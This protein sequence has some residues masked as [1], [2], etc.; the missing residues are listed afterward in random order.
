MKGYWK[1]LFLTD[2]PCKNKLALMKRLNNHIIEL[3][4]S[5]IRRCELIFYN[6]MLLKAVPP[7][8]NDFYISLLEVYDFVSFTQKQSLSCGIKIVVFLGSFLW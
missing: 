6:D 8:T 4:N 5:P 2:G 3:L 7:R 1:V